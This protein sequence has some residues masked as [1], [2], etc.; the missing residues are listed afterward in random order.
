M[1]NLD[2]LY[3]KYSAVF[4]QQE[5]SKDTLVY[6]NRRQAFLKSLDFPVLFAGVPVEPGLNEE[7]ASTWTKL[8][9][10]PA[11]LYLTGINQTDCFLLLDPK[12]KNEI[13]FLPKKDKEKEFWTGVKLGI[14]ESETEEAKIITGF[15]AIEDSDSFFTFTEK[16][17]KENNLKKIGVYYSEFYKQDSNA[18]FVQEIQNIAQKQNI[19]VES[20]AKMF[21]EK[22]LVLDTF[23]LK[24]AEEAIKNTGNAFEKML[25]QIKNFSTERDVSLFLNYEMLKNTDSDLAFPTIAASGKNACCLHYTKNDEPLKK[26]SLV[27]LDFGVRSGTLCSDISRTFP[28]SG[29][30][31]PLQKKIYQIV[32]DAQKFHEAQVKPGKTLNELDKNVWNF[33]NKR[34]DVLKREGL[35]IELLYESRPHGV[36]HFIGEHVHEGAYL[37]RLLNKTLEPGMLIS[38][39]PGVYGHFSGNIG[40][41]FYDEWIGIRVEDDLLVT[42]NGCKNLSVQI[43]K[44]IEAIENLM[45]V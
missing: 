42:E 8:I 24:K 36:S 38:N 35:E 10:D 37:G 33:I 21:L 23:R 45:R 25:S 11:F 13:L 4:I 3:Q 16:Y 28:V 31:N 20:I 2:F 22:R 30:F 19:Q 40:G 27:L 15:S 12:A 18:K 7:F 6:Q 41:I 34:L 44:T 1:E 39:E 5:K 9:Q 29:K 32:L 14:S 43:P 17:F 26:D